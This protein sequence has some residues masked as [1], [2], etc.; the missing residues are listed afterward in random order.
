MQTAA[1][2]TCA[3]GPGQEKAVAHWGPLVEQDRRAALCQ[4]SLSRRFEGSLSRRPGAGE[5]CSARL[6]QGKHASHSPQSRDG[7]CKPADRDN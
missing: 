7:S 1:N 4:G 3:S 2:E 6:A 5:S